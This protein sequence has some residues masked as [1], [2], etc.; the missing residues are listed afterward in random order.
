MALAAVVQMCSSACVSD[1]VEKVK[2]YL[3]RAESMGAQL[4]VLPE[5]FALMSD[6]SQVQVAASETLGGFFT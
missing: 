2:Q 1:N 3:C 5:N 6:D 4:V